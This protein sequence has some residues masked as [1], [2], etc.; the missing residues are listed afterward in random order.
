MSIERT[1]VLEIR[2]GLDDIAETRQGAIGAGL[3]ANGISPIYVDFGNGESFTP[4]GTAIQDYRVLDPDN[5]GRLVQSRHG[6]RMPITPSTYRIR[7]VPDDLRPAFARVAGEI[8]G[9]NNGELCTRLLS[10]VGMRH[11]LAGLG[12][13]EHLPPTNPADSGSIERTLQDSAGDM[14]FVKPMIGYSDVGGDTD[15]LIRRARYLPRDE[16][17]QQIRD[18][19]WG[20]VFVQEDIAGSVDEVVEHLAID[21]ATVPELETRRHHTIRLYQMTGSHQAG[22]SP[23][24]DVAEVRLISPADIGRPQPSHY[25]LCEPEEVFEALSD[26]EFQDLHRRVT[27]RVGDRY[28]LNYCAIDYFL[29]KQGRVAIDALHVR[30]WLPSIKEGDL[31]CRTVSAEVRA[32]SALALGT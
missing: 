27:Q 1:A 28:G 20:M 16:V 5:P 31:S 10:R 29:T 30:P 3:E 23:E 6:S 13:S 32:L 11:V 7:D 9:Y 8:P 19:R 26:I 17:A 25:E 12:F 18:P 15:E 2:R 22:R 24:P 4:D 14:V 21:P